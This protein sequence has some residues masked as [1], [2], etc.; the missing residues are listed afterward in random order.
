MYVG[1]FDRPWLRGPAVWSPGVRIEHRRRIMHPWGVTIFLNF[2]KAKN[3]RALPR[4]FRHSVG[5]Q[6]AHPPILVLDLLRDSKVRLLRPLHLLLRVG[7]E[8]EIKLSQVRG[9][10]RPICGSREF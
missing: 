9:T 8:G 6:G 10:L 2:P 5:S 4:A 7:V 1:D 3:C